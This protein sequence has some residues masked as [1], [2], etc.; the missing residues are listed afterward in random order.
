[1]LTYPHPSSPEAVAVDGGSERYGCLAGGGEVSQSV[2]SRRLE[3]EGLWEE[4]LV[5]SSS[6]DVGERLS[7]QLASH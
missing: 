2:S 3:R 1:V 6:G 4:W 5:D 7:S